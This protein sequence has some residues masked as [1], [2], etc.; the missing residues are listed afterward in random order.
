MDIR[1]KLYSEMTTKITRGN[2]RGQFSNA[3]PVLII[4]IIDYMPFMKGNKICFPNADLE[5]I[6]QTNLQFYDNECKT[7]IVKPFFYLDS[8][9]FYELV[10]K[11]NHSPASSTTLSGK[12][13]RE[14]LA[15]AKLDDDLWE[16]L[17]DKENRE[18]LKQTIINRY[19]KE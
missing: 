12:Y 9:P 7:P 19:L 13:L 10:W 6:Y 5:E 3:K 2:F 1:I 14:N 17:Q 18:Y 15:Y 16:L 11:P 8:E 4:S